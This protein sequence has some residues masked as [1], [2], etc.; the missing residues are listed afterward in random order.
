VHD[1]RRIDRRGFLRLATAGVPLLTLSRLASHTAQAADTAF[2]IAVLPDTQNYVGYDVPRSRTDIFAG[3]TRWIVEHLAAEKIVFVSHVGDVVNHGAQKTIE[4]QRAETAM[5]LLHGRVPYSVVPGN[6]DYNRISDRSSGLSAFV[7]RYGQAR[8]AGMPWYGGCSAN[9][10]NHYQRFEGGGWS[11]L[12]LGLELEAPDAALEWAAG[13]IRA[14]PGR[15]T[16]VST[17]SYVN[18]TTGRPKDHQ[19]KGNSGEQI[20]QKLVRQNPQIFMTLNGHF[21]ED[22]GERA[23]TSTNDAGLP[24]FEMCA[25]YQH[26]SNGGSGW[27]RLIRF[28]PADN[29][30]AVRTYSPWLDAT[31][32]DRDSSFSFPLD[33]AQRFGDPGARSPAPTPP[34]TATPVVPPGAPDHR[35][36]LPVIR[37]G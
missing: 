27:M 14:H 16:I 28:E 20:W 17:H 5:G 8:Y 24:V 7:K 32:D 11:F 2:T 23:Q 21:Y 1:P 37:A 34:P 33:F 30:I 15:P 13:V 4:W 26:Y 12:H 10:A 9:Q 6:H 29:R 22:D 18:D 35:V 19:F 25:D 36:H 31:M 3:Q